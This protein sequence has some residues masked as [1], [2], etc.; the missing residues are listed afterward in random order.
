MK[1]LLVIGIA[2]FAFLAIAKVF[3]LVFI[4]FSTKQAFYAVGSAAMAYS[5]FTRLKSQ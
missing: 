5:L 1:A 4:A 3:A 2:A